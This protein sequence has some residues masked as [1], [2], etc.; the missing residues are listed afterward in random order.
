MS[1]LMKPLSK[2]RRIFLFTASFL[3]PVCF[4]FWVA[5]GP[6]PA[7][8]TMAALLMTTCCAAIIGIAYRW[9]KPS[10]FD[11]A[12]AGYFAVV[13]LALMLW[14]TGAMAALS[15]YSITG[16]YL[17]LFA[18]AFV[19]PLLGMEPF[20]YYYAKRRTPEDAWGDPVF[21]R[22]NRIMTLVWSAVFALCLVSSLY[23]SFWTGVLIPWALVIGFGLPFTRRFPD[24]YL[25]RLGLPSLSEQ[26]NMA[27]GPAASGLQIPLPGV[28]PESAW[29]AISRMPDTFCPDAAGDLDAVLGLIV[30]GA[31]NFE[32]Y[33]HIHHGRCEI[34]RSPSR[35]P[36]L[37]IRTP[38]GVWLAIARRERDGREAFMTQ[39]YTAEGNLGLLLQMNRLFG[40]PRSPAR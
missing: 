15:G 7:E 1:T 21:I 16:I 9:D 3:P 40:G 20:T 6:A 2:S 11:W 31:E 14:P 33:L 30:S 18:A 19:P 8:M 5:S 37:F 4:K 26:K 13:S 32:A 25:K 12:I 39:A 10:Y 27:R 22:I 28:L 36:D 17:C 35:K 38:A 24:Y 34:G 29:Q 23:P